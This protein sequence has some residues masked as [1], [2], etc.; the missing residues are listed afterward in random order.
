MAATK[1]VP[2][3]P[4]H[5]IKT[6]H[7]NNVIFPQLHQNVLGGDENSPMQSFFAPIEHGVMSSGHSAISQPH[8]A[9]I[10]CEQK[11]QSINSLIVWF[12]ARWGWLMAL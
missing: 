7:A 8:P 11:F 9:I 10:P 1:P 6:V 3:P 2:H 12:H 5:Q 4:R